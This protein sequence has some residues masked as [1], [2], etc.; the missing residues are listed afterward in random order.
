MKGAAGPAPLWRLWVGT[1]P[2][3]FRSVVVTGAPC[4]PGTPGSASLIADF[5][6]VSA[7]PPLLGSLTGTPV[8][9]FRAHAKNPG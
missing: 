2:L 5:A 7:S 3:R 9:G 6:P 1:A 4:V 8:L